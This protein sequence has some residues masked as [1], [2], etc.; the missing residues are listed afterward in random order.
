[1]RI[2][3][4]FLL[5]C[6]FWQLE[7]QA[8]PDCSTAKLTGR[9]V[10]PE[11]PEYDAARQEYNTSFDRFP[12]VIVFAQDNQDI[13]NA[14]QWA[15]LHKRP[16]R[17]RSGRHNYEGLSV[18]D[19]GVII[20]VSEMKKI[21]INTCHQT[22][23]VETGITD[24][25]LAEALSQHH[26]IVPNGLCFTTGIAGFTLGGGQSAFCR[27]LGL[28]IDQLLEVEMVDAHGRIL[29]ANARENSDL[30]WA[31]RGGG[32]GNFGVCTKFTFKTHRI[33]QVV[34]ANIGWALE[35]LSAVLTVWQSY[36]TPHADNRL[37]PLLSLVNSPEQVHTFFGY[38]QKKQEFQQKFPSAEEPTSA[39]ITFQCVFLGSV[40]QLRK[41][42]RP[43]VKA[44]TPQNIFI[45][46][47][48]WI[49]ADFR[50]GLTQPVL[51]EPFKSTGPFV[52]KA[53][54]NKAIAIIKEFMES[55]PQD[56]VVAI[57]LHG[58][59]GAVASVKPTETAYY[60][61]NGW[62]N[63][64]PWATWSSPGGADAG[65]DW[66]NRLTHKLRRYTSGAYVN[67]PDL[68]LERWQKAYYGENYP[69]LQHVKRT[70]DPHNFF[71]FPQSIKP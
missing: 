68:S 69:R 12:H 25:E 60:Y 54:P 4:L 7:L 56:N 63:I 64:N 3:L 57:V 15:R 10:F 53:L 26:L 40:K 17:L 59:N 39:A 8:N 14:I 32:G 49:E 5:I 11:S 34:Y 50:I 20:D 65:I 62:F 1:M 58:L 67:S 31:L 41:I 43:L 37:T 47:M 35:D 48:A 18:V 16:L 2:I 9:L 21:E 19:H 55:P 38:A 61:R 70:Y 33:D 51:P 29:H 71:H 46:K 42:L 28:A 45:K 22:V 6:G 27:Q 36:S 44:G 13:V 23:T 66:V 52:P 30:F 24:I